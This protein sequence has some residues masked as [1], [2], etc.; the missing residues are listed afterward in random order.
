MST[1]EASAQ[2]SQTKPSDS[3]V[4]SA[5]ICIGAAIDKLSNAIQILESDLKPVLICPAKPIEE[6]KI[7]LKEQTC[8]LVEDL[9]DICTKILLQN[10]HIH[11][12]I[13]RCAL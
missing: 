13:A 5:T 6:D 7:E 1:N 10:S 3:L 9:D 12:I 2:V 8:K 4:T 11:D